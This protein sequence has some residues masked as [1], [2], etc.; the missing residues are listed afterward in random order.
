MP[1]EMRAPEHWRKQAARDWAAVLR[2]EGDAELQDAWVRVA[3]G[4]EKLAERY[5][6]LSDRPDAQEVRSED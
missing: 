5:E 4:F 6:Q 2:F 3:V 1:T